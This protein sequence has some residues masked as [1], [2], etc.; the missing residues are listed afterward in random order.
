MRGQAQGNGC[1]GEIEA[2]AEDREVR[3]D[4]EAGVAVQRAGR[5]DDQ[6]RHAG[7]DEGHAR[8]TMTHRIGRPNEHAVSAATSS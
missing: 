2:V 8:Q 7:R 3:L 6:R 4:V 1:D 5:G